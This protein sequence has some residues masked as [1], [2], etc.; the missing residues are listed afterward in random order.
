MN[1]NA[2]QNTRPAPLSPSNRF[3]SAVMRE[4]AGTTDA[5]MQVTDYQRSLIQGYFICIDRA[6]KTAEAD[7]LAKNAKNTNHDYD[8]PDPCTW[9]NVNL[10]D[11]ALDLVYYARAGL[12]MMG[13][14]MLFPIPFHN[15]NHRYDVT[16]MEG[17][18]GKKLLAE[19][20]ALDK[21]ES[22]TVEV[23]YSTDNFR[24]IKKGS[25][26]ATDTYQF[27]ITQPFDRGQ[28]VGGFAYIEFSDCTKNK[29]VMM[30][31]KDIMKR[32]PK[33]ASKQFWGTGTGEGDDGW[34]DEMCRKTLLREAYSTKHLP[35]DPKKIDDAYQQS[36]LAE[37]R[38]AALAA[39][40]EAELNANTIIIPAAPQAPL[41]PSSQ[42]V[43]LPPAAPTPAPVPAATP[44]QSAQNAAEPEFP[45]AD[46]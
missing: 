23:V 31:I 43:P 10:T 11:L 1:E 2:L 38:Y 46:W 9:E 7:R 35:L 34:F 37:A 27:E 36:K 40:Q 26:S 21:P 33:Y 13:D 29:L 19:K 6:L 39:Q 14:N 22:V 41:P 15:K 45:E 32:K 24:P 20:Y 17:Y 28:I 3:T 12:D 5:T 30:S 44:A 18:N 4:F 16:L 42:P 8:N 25:A